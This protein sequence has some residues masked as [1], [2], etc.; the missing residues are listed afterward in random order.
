MATKKK[1]GKP[2]KPAKSAKAGKNAKPKAAPAPQLKPCPH[3]GTKIAKPKAAALAAKAVTVKAAASSCSVEV[4]GCLR[5]SG[6]NGPIG[7]NDTL[8]ALG[9]NSGNFAIC[10][11][12][13]F[14][15]NFNAGSFPAGMTAG[16]AVSKIC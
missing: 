6:A 14:G 15:T 3:C 9:V 7:P 1:A 4:V 16:Q 13:K 10:I 2:A 8:G 12:G 11:N 5:S